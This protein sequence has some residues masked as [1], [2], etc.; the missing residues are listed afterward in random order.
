METYWYLPSE[1]LKDIKTA[2][3]VFEEYG[4]KTEITEV[5]DDGF[6]YKAT[7]TINPKAPKSVFNIRT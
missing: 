7:M 5:S 6:S 4:V 3:E 1:A 2:D